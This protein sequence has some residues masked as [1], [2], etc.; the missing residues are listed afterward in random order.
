MRDKFDTLIDDAVKSYAAAE[1][2]PELAATILRHAQDERRPKR[3]GWKLTL[4][5]AL[6]LAAA[7]VLAVVLVG[8]LSLPQ[9]PTAVAMAPAAPKVP[10]TMKV[11]EPKPV[12]VQRRAAI[13]RRNARP[14]ARPLPAPYTKQELALLAFVEQ[15]PREAAAFAA[16]QK[17]PIKP[18]RQQ[19]L[20]ISHLEIAPLTIASLD[21]EK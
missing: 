16:D 7:A 18:L 19:P 12:L 15:H 21:Q 5:F 20:T 14:A 1:P 9:A 11:L 13:A 10:K 6:P 8:R 2:S 17:R 4:A 3:N